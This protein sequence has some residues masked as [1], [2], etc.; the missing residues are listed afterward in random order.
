MRTGVAA[1]IVLVAVALVPSAAAAQLPV[2][3][4]DGVR[5]VRERGAIVVV[6]TQRAERLWRR[7]AGRV[8]SVYCWERGEPDENGFLSVSGGGSSLRAPKRGRRLRTGDG[9]RGM[10]YCR[11]WRAPRWVRRGRERVRLGRR[12]I[13]SI[14]L[15]QK[16]AVYLDE[17]SKARLPAAPPAGGL[18]AWR[19]E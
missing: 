5:I 6:F 8:V 12:L 9:T 1:L 19:D 18:T 3:E 4:A 14:P 10:D 13:V 11:V 15:T 16:G 7:V 2:G 17:Q